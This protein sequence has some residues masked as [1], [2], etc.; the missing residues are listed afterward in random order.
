MPRN[1]WRG[2]FLFRVITDATEFRRN[3]LS[4]GSVFFQRGYYDQ[5]GA[6]FDLALRDDPASAEALYGMGSVYLQ[7]QKTAEARSSFERVTK[8]SASYPETLPNAWNN[9]GLLAT[10]EGRTAEA[11]PLF[12]EALRLSPDHL[13]ALENL[14][15]AYRQQKQWDAARSVLEHAVKVGPQDPEA[16]YSL[17]MVYA[18]LD[19]SDR[20]YEYLQ[21]ALKVSSR[22]SRSAEQSRR[23]IPAYPAP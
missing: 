14:G 21:A 6:A 8:L 12:R 19:D 5:A 18:Q 11:I 1:A 23:T 15:N 7:Q 2:R 4:Y 3:Y 10:R 17:G 13:V 20:A 16:N 9:L 22:V